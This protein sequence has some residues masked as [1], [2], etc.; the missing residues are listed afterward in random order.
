MLRTKFCVAAALIAATNWQVAAQAFQN[1]RAP[2][3]VGQT[4]DVR[5]EISLADAQHRTAV[6]QGLASATAIKLRLDHVSGP[7]V[8]PGAIVIIRDAGNNEVARYAGDELAAERRIWT[9][10]IKGTA[11]QVELAGEPQAGTEFR[12]VIGA[13]ASNVPP[14]KPTLNIVRDFD[15]E[16]IEYIRAN[17]PEIFVAGRPVAKISFLIREGP[18]ACTGFM[19]SDDRMITNH[20][21][22]N[23]EEICKSADIIFGFN[24]SDSPLGDE[25]QR[26]LRLVD[27]D[28]DLD[29]A[30]IEVAGSP[31]K[32]WGSLAFSDAVP[33]LNE[34]AVVVQHPA[35]FPK[36]VSRIDCIVSTMPADGVKAG[37][38]SDFGHSCDTMDGSSGSPV[39]R[40]ADLKVIGLHHWG[41]VDGAGKWSAENRAVQIRLIKERFGL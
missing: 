11:S 21:C 8:P 37:K 35:G 13:V 5:L 33:A 18:A 17:Q 32:R 34:A 36:F 41:F 30:L 6:A 10:L 24:K 40:R 31:G 12:V 26:C 22:I 16:N 1:G 25:M 38:E 2:L 20:H 14:Q 27:K 23:T 7:N 19:V 39:L 29:A 3:V 9:P 4:E 15:L 28:E